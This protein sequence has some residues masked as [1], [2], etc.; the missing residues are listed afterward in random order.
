V[1]MP[2]WKNV[3][4]LGT[5]DQS[6]MAKLKTNYP[7]YDSRGITIDIQHTSNADTLKILPTRHC[8]KFEYGGAWK[9]LC[10]G[11][12]TMQDFPFRIWNEAL[13]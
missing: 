6:V 12:D 1:S 9:N 13:C 2:E 7:R 3:A 10:Y 8:A 4:S 11:Y 5:F